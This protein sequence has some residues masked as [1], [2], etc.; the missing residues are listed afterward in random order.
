MN[1]LFK[2]S[3]SELK[4]VEGNRCNYSMR[5]TLPFPFTP[6]SHPF[7]FLRTPSLYFSTPCTPPALY[8]PKQ[9][10][11]Y[12]NLVFFLFN[13]E[14]GKAILRVVVS[15]S[16]FHPCISRKHFLDDPLASAK[17]LHM[18]NA[19]NLGSVTIIFPDEVQ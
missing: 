18:Y 4:A 8:F 7:K 13:S 16:K 12:W 15:R 11:R 9:D 1:P 2:P 19:T 5:L 14:N 17:R 10:L 3:R 6:S